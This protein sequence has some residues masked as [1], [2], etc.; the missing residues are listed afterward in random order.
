M[1]GIKII[2]LLAGMLAV[3]QSYAQTDALAYADSL[4]KVT[5]ITYMNMFGTKV[6]IP[7]PG[8]N[9]AVKKNIN[10]LE[11]FNDSAQVTGEINVIEMPAYAVVQLPAYAPTSLNTQGFTGNLYKKNSSEATILTFFFEAG[12]SKVLIEAS[13]IGA[14]KKTEDYYMN[15]L[16]NVRYDKNV[17]VH[18]RLLPL[19]ARFTVDAAGSGYSLVGITRGAYW[20]SPKGIKPKTISDPQMWITEHNTTNISELR[21]LDVPAVPGG[22]KTD[23]I[24][25][26]V[27]EPV[28]DGFKVY[29]TVMYIG[30]APNRLMVYQ[31]ART[32]GIISVV[33]TAV[34]TTDFEKNQASFAAMA[35]TIH[36]RGDDQIKLFDH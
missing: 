27:E 12:E 9:A 24:T 23:T 20:Y 18:T 30:V 11:I 29:T 10:V 28:I 5:G 31:A 25:K 2:F 33:M 1:R 16:K 14:D 8:K 36:V 35:K 26:N 13:F 7:K 22:V 4:S 17:K 21:Y 3:C 19:L 15:I 6:F 32:N 34:A